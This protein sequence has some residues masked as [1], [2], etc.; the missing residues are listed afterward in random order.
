[1]DEVSGSGPGRA[2]EPKAAIVSFRIEARSLMNDERP[3]SDGSSML[4]ID[5]IG[6]NTAFEPLTFAFIQLL[7]PG[8]SVLTGTAPADIASM[9]TSGRPSK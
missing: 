4:F 7:M 3:S 8:R 5:G 2:P 6:T 1:M 9:S